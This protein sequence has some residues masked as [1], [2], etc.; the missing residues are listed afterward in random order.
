MISKRRKDRPNPLQCM[1]FYMLAI[2]AIRRNHRLAR[3]DV[4]CLVT[5]HCMQLETNQLLTGSVISARLA[6]IPKVTYRRLRRLEEK[7]FIQTIRSS[8]PY[9]YN[10]STAGEYIARAFEIEMSR[11]L[12]STKLSAWERI[13]KKNLSTDRRIKYLRPATRRGVKLY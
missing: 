6:E 13:K 10:V 4:I 2:N 1:S 12:N 8:K 9:L 7:G 3:K 5:M 11:L